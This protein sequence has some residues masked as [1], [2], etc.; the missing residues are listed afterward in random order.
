MEAP[1]SQ[2]VS[3]PDN[4]LVRVLDNEAVLLN[5][6]RETYFGLDDVG[7]HMW[8]RLTQSDTIQSAYDTLLTE[9]DI[10]G[11]QLRADLIDLIGQLANRGLLVLDHGEFV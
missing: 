8:L 1:F 7:T 9:Y 3:V 4:V 2:R 5:L 6:D 11:A 10:E